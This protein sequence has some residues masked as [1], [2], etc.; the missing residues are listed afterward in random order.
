MD[1]RPNPKIVNEVIDDLHRARLLVYTDNMDHGVRIDNQIMLLRKKIGSAPELA[2]RILDRRELADRYGGVVDFAVHVPRP[3]ADPRQHHAHL[4]MT[5]RQVGPDGLGAR[6]AL[7]LSATA[8]RVAS[9][10]TRFWGR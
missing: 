4:L 3:Q 5:T 8:A 2:A 9:D 6:T 1:C 10:A 7:N